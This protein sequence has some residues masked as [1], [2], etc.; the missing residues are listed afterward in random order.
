MGHHAGRWFI[1]ATSSADND[2]NDV[3][4]AIVQVGS[5]RLRDTQEDGVENL[6][7]QLPD[8]QR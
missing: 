4:D 7:D 5:R 6:G 8:P 2:D 3:V 1:S